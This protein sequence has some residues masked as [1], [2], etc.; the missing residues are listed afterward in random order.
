MYYVFFNIWKSNM[1]D[2]NN[3]IREEEIEVYYHRTLILYIKFYNITW[4]YVM[5]GLSCKPTEIP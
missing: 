5:A 2:N 1:H 4:K 3:K